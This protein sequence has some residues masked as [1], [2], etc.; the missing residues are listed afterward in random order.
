MRTFNLK[1]E[2]KF[3]HSKK[4]STSDKESLLFQLLNIAQTLLFNYADS[5]TRK[6]K[7]F[8]KI[9]Y[10]K[11]KKFYLKKVEELIEK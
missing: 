7:S 2:L 1:K 6:L 10:L 5:E 8:Y 9:V 11:T 3:I 4:I